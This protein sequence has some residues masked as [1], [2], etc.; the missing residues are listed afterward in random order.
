MSFAQK[1][2]LKKVVCYKCREKGHYARD[3]EKD[4]ND[5]SEMTS[6]SLITSAVAA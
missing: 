3:C 1:K 6:G 4:S 2:K 5:E